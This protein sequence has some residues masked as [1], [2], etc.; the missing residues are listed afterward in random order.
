MPITPEIREM[1]SLDDSEPNA[2]EDSTDQS[3]QNQKLWTREGTLLLI[4]KIEEYQHEFENGLKKIVWQKI[5]LDCSKQLGKNISHKNCDEKWKSLKRTYKSI[6]VHNAQ[7]GKQRRRWEFFNVIHAFM[8]NKPEIK[9]IAT[10]S[11]ISGLQTENSQ[12]K[13]EQC[14]SSKCSEEGEEDQQSTYESSFT[15]K[16]KLRTSGVE[17]RHKQKMA[18]Q[19]RFN[20]LFEKLIEKL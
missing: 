4:R 20:D 8:Y 16:R 3:D 19:D 14:S 6:V 11:N 17:A 13:D 10:C 15:K 2:E 12:S 9:P 7:S 5:A 1:Y 18:R